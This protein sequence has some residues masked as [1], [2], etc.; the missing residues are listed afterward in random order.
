MK[1]KGHH[2]VTTNK[3]IGRTFKYKTEAVRMFLRTENQNNLLLYRILIR[4]K[5]IGDGW[6]KIG[7]YLRRL[8]YPGS[9]Y[10]PGQNRENN[11]FLISSF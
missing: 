10:Q 6:A 1:P 2:L 7:Q 4:N 3:A 5:T 8:S 11:S 9:A